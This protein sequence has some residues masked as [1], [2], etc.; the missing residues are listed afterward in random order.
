MLLLP[1]REILLAQLGGPPHNRVVF[2]FR[3]RVLRTEGEGRALDDQRSL[4]AVE[5]DELAAVVIQVAA[6][7]NAE[8]GIVVHG[9]DEIGE[10]AAIFPAEESAGGLRA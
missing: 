2:G 5:A 1:L 9:L 10:L 3:S 7:R 4:G 8:V 6:H